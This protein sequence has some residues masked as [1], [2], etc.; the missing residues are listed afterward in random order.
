MKDEFFQIGKVE[1]LKCEI[2]E[3]PKAEAG[4]SKHKLSCLKTPTVLI[5]IYIA[6]CN[7]NFTMS[8]E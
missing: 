1:D 8:T 2:L 6:F 7:V 3:E 4:S 5:A